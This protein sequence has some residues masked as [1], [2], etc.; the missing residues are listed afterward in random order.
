MMITILVAIVAAA[1][2]GYWIYQRP[3]AV[4]QAT[5]SQLTTQVD[6][7]EMALPVLV[8]LNQALLDPE[9]ASDLSSLDSVE[10]I[11]RD[12]F[13]VS[14]SLTEFDR[15]SAASHAASSALDGVRLVR[16]THAYRAAVIP[17]LATPILEIDPELVGLDEAA[18]SFGDWQRAFDDVRTALPEGVLSG[19][20]EQLDILSGD[21]T[22]FLVRYVEALRQKDRGAVEY[23]LSS[24]TARLD[25]TARSLSNTVEDVHARVQARI[26]ETLAALDPISSR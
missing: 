23:V 17:M 13:G 24:L 3:V 16:E 4:A 1:S 8:E 2:I 14:G 10:T 11:A 12:L 26:D 18:R 6:A 20:T 22:S 7:L 21:L 19:V 15:R 9:P 25:A 5:N